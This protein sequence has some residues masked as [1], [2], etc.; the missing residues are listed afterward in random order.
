MSALPTY[1]AIIGLEVHAQLSTES[2]IFCGCSTRFGAEP[3]SQICPVCTGQPGVLPV[4]NGQAVDHGLRLAL[5]LG[6]TVRRRSRFARKNYF[7]PDLPK[8]YQISQYDEPLAEGG[9]V[10]IALAGEQ[11]RIRLTRIHL[12][13][14]AGKNLHR[15]K[16]GSSLV[17]LN[18]AGV[19]LLEIVSE[20]DL[21]SGAEAAE[22]L[23]TLRAIVRT[24]GICDGNMEQGSLR[25]DANISLRPRGTT[26]LGTRAEVKNMN[27]FRFVERALD[28]EAERQR[29]LLERGETVLQETRLWN[30][31]RGITE[32]MRS[33][34][35]AHDYRYFPEPDLPPLFVEE[36]LLE[37]LRAEI[38]ELPL[39]RRTRLVTAL[40]VSDYDAT[41]LTRERELGDYFEA[42]VAAGGRPKAAANWIL[43][44]LLSR[45]DDARQV[46]Q[47]PV[48]PQA[49]AALLDLVGSGKLSGKLAKEI[50]PRMWETGRSAEAI[51]AEE[52][53]FQESDAAAIERAVLE[54]IAGNPVQVQ[55]Y[56]AG[57]TKVFGFFVGQVMKATSG[58]ANPQVLNALLEKHLA[59]GED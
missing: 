38:P 34:E 46:L 51:A 12:E 48:T 28:Y 54:V 8:G 27:S 32:S 9:A 37:R 10:E 49:L 11:R 42:V 6:C 25:C 4:L 57:K 53:L 45:V 5:A 14:D 21:R 36:E 39:A 50:W 23:R 55:Q 59:A 19:P 29:T 26:A 2:K 18:R 35:E 3:N 58:R 33:K 1:E 20:P 22:Y 52:N 17:D 7:Y 16:A 44:E 47:A 13:E 40:G 30:A 15:P 56:R 24:L 43:T 31:E 41:E